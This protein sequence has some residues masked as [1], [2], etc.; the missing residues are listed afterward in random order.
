MGCEC[1][2]QTNKIKSPSK[3][4][5]KAKLEEKISKAKLEIKSLK[6]DSI[7]HSR[8][9]NTTIK[10]YNIISSNLLITRL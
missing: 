8:I 2:K 9:L 10:K 4:P 7:E 5:D 3:I 6:P 1:S